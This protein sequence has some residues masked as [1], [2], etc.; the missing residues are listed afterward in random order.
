MHTKGVSERPASPE[1]VRA[2]CYL[3]GPVG[4]VF[5]LVS[6]PFNRFWAVR[7]HAV[8]SILFFA[9]W[10]TAWAIME[11]LEGI[12][13]WFPAMVLEECQLGFNICGLLMWAAL[14][15][16]ALRGRKLAFFSPMHALAARMASVRYGRERR[17]KSGHRILWL[18]SMIRSLR[19]RNLAHAEPRAT[20]LM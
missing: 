2:L 11:A 6:R 20:E 8:H 15:L 12:S 3:L 19:F 9:S 4:G 14:M 5:F 1:W 18:R 13:P 16:T 10:L 17:R 7:F